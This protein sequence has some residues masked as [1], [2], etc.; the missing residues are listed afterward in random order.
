MR[1]MRG[2]RAGKKKVEP[3]SGA[4]TTQMPTPSI[5]TCN[6]PQIN[7]PTSAKKGTAASITTPTNTK[8]ISMIGIMTSFHTKCS[9]IRTVRP[10]DKQQMHYKQMEIA[11][12]KTM[13]GIIPTMLNLTIETSTTWSRTTSGRRRDTWTNVQQRERTKLML[14]WRQPET[15]D[16]L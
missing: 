7:L 9:R 4:E 3:K 11:T 16:I 14:Y 13:S 5:K 12:C 15:F 6:T 1:K 2:S 8:G 10:R